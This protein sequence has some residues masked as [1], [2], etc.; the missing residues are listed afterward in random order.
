MTR[1]SNPVSVGAFSFPIEMSG[2]SASSQ[3]N[4]SGLECNEV[5]EMPR[6]LGSRHRE[7]RPSTLERTL[8]PS[9][10]TM[11]PGL[12]KARESKHCVERENV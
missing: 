6:E 12:G 11:N 10:V 1:V 3:G 2:S 9:L 4:A 8:G 5:Q 7:A